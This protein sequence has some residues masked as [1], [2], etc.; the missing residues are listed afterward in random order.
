MDGW[1]TYSTVEQV[2]T[3]TIRFVHQARLDPRVSQGVVRKRCA[4]D[5][6]GLKKPAGQSSQ[7]VIGSGLNWPAG[8]LQPRSEAHTE[9]MC[10]DKVPGV[11]ANNKTDTTGTKQQRAKRPLTGAALTPC[12]RRR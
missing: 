7:S 12:T 9:E 1:T 5:P 6:P 11:E 10:G 3:T 8:Q 4:Q 2:L